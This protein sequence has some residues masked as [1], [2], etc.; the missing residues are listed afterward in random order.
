MFGSILVDER[1]GIAGDLSDIDHS[2]PDGVLDLPAERLPGEAVAARALVGERRADPGLHV[3]DVP[4]EVFAFELAELQLLQGA[5]EPVHAV[6]DLLGAVFEGG[7]FARLQPP[8]LV[9]LGHEAF[10]GLGAVQ[11]QRERRLDQLVGVLLDGG[12]VL[13][14]RLHAQGGVLGGAARGFDEV[15]GVGESEGA[16]EAEEDNQKKN[17]KVRH[18]FCFRFF[19]SGN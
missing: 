11:G 4:V 5:R 16:M 15:G 9:A 10:G 19:F 6:A 8:E 3:A 7:V 13:R 2:A 12:G 14:Q 17:P 18:F 1:E